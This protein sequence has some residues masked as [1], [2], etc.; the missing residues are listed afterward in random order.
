MRN[1]TKRFLVM[2][3]IFAMTTALCAC[4]GGKAGSADADSLITIG[5]P[6]DLD[7]SLDP[8]IAEG[9][10][11]R[12]VLFNVFEGLVKPNSNGDL[13][14]AVA[15]DYSINEDGT[16]YTFTLREGVKFHNGSK[17]TVQD[18]KASLDKC[19][20]TE[21]GEPL[22]AA[23]SAVKEIN[24]PDDKTIEVVLKESDT[25]FLPNMTAAILPADHLDASTQPIGTGPY[26]YVSRSPQENII[27]ESF[28]DY[29]GDKA[30][31]KT[32]VLKIVS[33]AD[34][35]VMNLEGGSIDLMARLSTTQ[36]AQLSDKFDVYEGTMNLVQALYINN[37]VE[38]LNNT[39]V[40]QALCYAVDIQEIMDFV[41]DG[42]GTETGSSMFPAF[43]K[44]YMKELNDTY[45]TDIDK[46]KKLLAEA[47]YPDGFEFTITVASNYQQHVDTAQVLKEQFKKIGVTANINLVE[48]DTWLNDVYIGRNFETTVV[49]VDAST[50]TASAMLG[51]FVSDS[52]KNFIN[53][54]NPEYDKVYAEAIATVDDN[55]RTEKYKT[56]EKIL[57][58]DAANVYIQ[59]LP[60]LVAVNKKFG[61][62]EFYPLYVMDF[63]KLYVK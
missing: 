41:S 17:V 61:G 26:K 19:A 20:G 10:G 24:T 37:S 6:Q 28:D 44:Y 23:F 57:S 4:A 60:N 33:D 55:V 29:W 2:L 14:P 30:K 58:E 18:V 59:D 49:G 8:H 54:S 52:G 21:S 39:K 45:N 36:A 32:V 1:F 63:S 25:D 7:D 56:C 3:L 62:Y 43:G 5:I 42:K 9:A 48:W 38:P 11:T 22:V 40:R 46:A 13:I 51:R 27:L 12:E 50:L 47:G 15:S 34:T 31:I 53:Y 16:V 35:I